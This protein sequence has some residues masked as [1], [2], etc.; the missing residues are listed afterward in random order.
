MRHWPARERHV[1]HPHH[2][3]RIGGARSTHETRT[4]RECSNGRHDKGTRLRDPHHDTPG[5]AALRGEPNPMAKSELGDVIR[6]AP[7]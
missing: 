1:R 2:E 6:S 5:P 7:Q 4:H 3:L